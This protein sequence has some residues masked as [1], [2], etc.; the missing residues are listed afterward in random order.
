MNAPD[1]FLTEDRLRA[2]QWC[3]LP[4]AVKEASLGAALA[5]RTPARAPLRCM[6]D[7]VPRPVR[8]ILAACW[9]LS[10]GL[11][12]ATPETP[13][14]SAPALARNDNTAPL[15]RTPALFASLEQT[16]LVLHELQFDLVRPSS[17]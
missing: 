14:T 6:V 12:L 1:D 15:L 9:T 17:R 4:E 2:M 8:C 7:F 16:N 11:R 5:A 13:H 10:L 3:P